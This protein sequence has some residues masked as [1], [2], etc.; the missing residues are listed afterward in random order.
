M[1]SSL[2]RKALSNSWQKYAEQI[3]DG[4]AILDDDTAGRLIEAFAAV[5]RDHFVEQPTRAFEDVGLSVGFGQSSPKPSTI[6]RMLGVLGLTS[7]MRILELGCGSGYCSALMSAAGAHVFA[8]EEIG[9]LAQRARKTLDA[10]GYQNVIVRPREGK[11]GWAEHAPFD[12]II[13]W[14]PCARMPTGLMQQLSRPHGRLLG[15][16]GEGDSAR[17][18]LWQTN[19]DGIADYQLERILVN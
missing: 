12:A 1:G 9:L 6:A 10:L 3:V 11:R 2:R 15:L 5:P 14:Q 8:L 19:Q 7:G 13:V 4:A 16:I 17:L 18:T